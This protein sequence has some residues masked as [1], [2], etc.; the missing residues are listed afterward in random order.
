[1]I[2]MKENGFGKQTLLIAFCIKS[3]GVEGLLT[4]SEQQSLEV[5]S[6]GNLLLI[7]WC[8]VGLLT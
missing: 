3:Y 8:R 1:M 7:P 5:G 4:P 6:F 2:M